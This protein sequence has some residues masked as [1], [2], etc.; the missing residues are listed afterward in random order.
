MCTIDSAEI[1]ARRELIHRIRASALAVDPTSDG[2]VLKLPPERD[3][4]VRALAIDE[5]RCCGFW[6][7]D[8]THNAG[9]VALRWDGPP[10]VAPL[11]EQLA[12]YFRGEADLD[13]ITGLF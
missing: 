3:A 10:D 12:A 1:P 6:G 2:F 8:I 5:K 9:M 7:F 4:D 11:V 13:S